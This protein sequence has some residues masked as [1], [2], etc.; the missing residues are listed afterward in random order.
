[1][2][3]SP[4]L[5]KGHTFASF[6]SLGTRPV[7]RY[8][9]NITT[10]MGAITSLSFLS[11]SGFSSSGPVALWGF[12]S[13]NSFMIPTSDTLISGITGWLF[14]FL[15]GTDL[16]SSL[17]VSTR[18]GTAICARLLSAKGVLGVKTDWNW[19]LR[20]SAL[21]LFSVYSLPYLHREDTPSLFSFQHQMMSTSKP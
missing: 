10:N 1:M 14:I 15:A 11:T 16:V 13:F 21:S 3:L 17:P 9:W 8:L 19:Q 12:K 2:L 18:S 5:N 20:I 7:S 6:Q 4:F